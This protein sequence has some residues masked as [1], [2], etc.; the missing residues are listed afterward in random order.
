M[1]IWHK[2]TVVS[3]RLP[4]LCVRQPLDVDGLGLDRQID[5]SDFRESV[6]LSSKT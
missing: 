5:A 4:L 3:H 2:P 1:S 6:P